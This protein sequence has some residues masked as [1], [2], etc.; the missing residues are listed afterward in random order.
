ML[1]RIFPL[2]AVACLATSSLRAETDPFIGQWKLSKTSDQMKVTK[3][4]AN[5]YSFDFGG[6]VESIA[7]DGTYQPGVAGTTLSVAADGPNWKVSRKKGAHMLL[8]AKWTLSKDGNVL[9]D[10]FTS[11]SQD[12]SPSTVKS[13]YERKAPG[14]GF[15]GTWVSA[16]LAT[17]SS[18][19]L[20]VR[21]YDSN[22]LSFVIPSAGQTLDVNFDGK[23]G[24]RLNARSVEIIR[25]SNGKVTQ[26]RQIDLSP[27][28][29]IMTMTV[30]FA[31]NAVP[32]VYVFERQHTNIE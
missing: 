24:R 2:F 14:L 8:T 15:A 16:A 7:V 12:G 17:S 23:D 27:D 1:S 9:N 13:E 5:T 4:G 18:V 32:N 28:F 25:R 29:K 11:F 31:G 20:Q 26:T 30:H 19:M 10:D 21:R 6:G 22:G 3:V